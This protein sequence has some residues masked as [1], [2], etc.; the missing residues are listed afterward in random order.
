MPRLGTDRAAVVVP[1]LNAAMAEFDISTP[2]RAAHFLAQIAQETGELR[3]LKELWG[4][5]L[6]QLKY[7]PPSKVAASLGNTEPG[8]GQR[9]LGRGAIQLTG[10]ANYQRASERFQV[11]LLANP[12]LASGDDFA[13]R[14][15]GAFWA[16]KAINKFAD[17]DDVRAVTRRVNGGLTHLAER[18]AYLKR[19]KLSL[20]G[21][22]A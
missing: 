14:I 2:L 16:D 18:T 4:P 3:W 13:F 1:L 7:E 17:A 20:Q 8:D 6:Q 9:F 10:R 11:D 19:A 12:H 15:A 21:V 22:P 5:T